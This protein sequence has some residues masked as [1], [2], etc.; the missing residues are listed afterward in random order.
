MKRRV[1]KL[2]ANEIKPV[3][4]SAFARDSETGKF[5][6]VAAPSGEEPHE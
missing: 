3:A 6:E 4:P 5:V 1:F 2:K